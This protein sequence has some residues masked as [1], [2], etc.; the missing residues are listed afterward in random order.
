MNR[1]KASKETRVVPVRIINKLEYHLAKQFQ[2]L[3]KI[4]MSYAEIKYPKRTDYLE[5][6]KEVKPYRKYKFTK[7]INQAIAKSDKELE[8]IDTAKREAPKIRQG[9]SAKVKQLEDLFLSKNIDESLKI[10]PELRSHTNL[11]NKASQPEEEFVKVQN[12]FLI[13]SLGL[14]FSGG[15]KRGP[16]QTFEKEDAEELLDK[17]LHTYKYTFLNIPKN[18]L[19]DYEYMVVFI[20]NLQKDSKPV[21]LSSDKFRLWQ[22]F[23]Y[24]QNPEY[25]KLEKLVD[26]YL[27][28]NDK[29]ALNKVI[30]LLPKFP[31][32]TKATQKNAEHLKVAYRGIPLHEDLTEEEIKKQEPKYAACSWSERV[33]ER[34]AQERGHMERQPR[35]D[36]G[37][38]LTYRVPKDAAILD[39]EVFGSVFGE[40]EVII[41]TTK[42]KLQNID[43]HYWDTS[44][45][46]WEE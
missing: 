18:K 42:A 37:V 38:I 30:T 5:F 12:P 43:I 28:S 22:T 25:I 29:Q 19:D 2:H 17:D 14:I 34:F 46:D 40:S 35:A 10:L 4:I 26:D 45:Q 41:D 27:Y 13:S 9:F 1:V 32:L 39:T 3:L 21:R 44:S 24:T 8:D 11:L 33:A 36:K 16:L 6:K 15:K 23:L 31:E 7:Y 20:Q